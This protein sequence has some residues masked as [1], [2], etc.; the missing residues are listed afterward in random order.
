MIEIRLYD[1][2]KVEIMEVDS[3]EKSVWMANENIG[4]YYR[5]GCNNPYEAI[6]LN[7]NKKKYHLA[8]KVNKKIRNIDEQ[9]KKLNEE[10]TRILNLLKLELE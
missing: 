10:K 9:I 6:L 2:G 5:S 8:E 7:G 3:N 4:G 1:D